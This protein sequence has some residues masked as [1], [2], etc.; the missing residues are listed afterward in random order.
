MLY[1]LRFHTH[2]TQAVHARDAP[3]T[4]AFLEW[5]YRKQSVV[6][7]SPK[8]LPWVTRAD[9]A[10]EC[11]RRRAEQGDDEDDLYDGETVTYTLYH[12][13]TGTKIAQQHGRP[14]TLDQ[15]AALAA[16]KPGLKEAVKR[17]WLKARRRKRARA[18]T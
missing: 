18:P 12:K 13:G 8:G 15:S 7:R 10:A 1:K 9:V 3:G 11:K 2:L 14:F 16:G 5:S 6:S 4:L 17:E